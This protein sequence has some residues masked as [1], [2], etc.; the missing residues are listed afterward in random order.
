MLDSIDLRISTYPPNATGR[1]ATDEEK[2]EYLFGGAMTT[3]TELIE[4]SERSQS[5][6]SLR[7][8]LML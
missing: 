8:G 6:V 1:D 2:E 5:K 7:T 4:S 3:H